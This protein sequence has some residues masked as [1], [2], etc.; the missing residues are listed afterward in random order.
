MSN[1]YLTEEAKLMEVRV[2]SKKGTVVK[3]IDPVLAEIHQRLQSHPQ[4]W[5]RSLQKDPSGFGDLEKKVHHAFQQMAFRCDGAPWIWDR[6]DWVRR[7]LG[8]SDKQVSLGLDWC[9][10]VHH[11]SLAL[12]LVLQGAERKRVFKKLHKWLRA[13]RW[14]KVVDELVGL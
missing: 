4:E 7:R 1:G 9:H 10:A 3:G 8:L 14:Q 11:V 12:A 13:G 2:Q 5:L 6:L